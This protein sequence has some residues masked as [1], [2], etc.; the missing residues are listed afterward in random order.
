M[1]S[2]ALQSP[3]GLV[4]RVAERLAGQAGAWHGRPHL[5]GIVTGV[6]GRQEVRRSSC[7]APTRCPTLCSETIR[8]DLTRLVIL[9]S[10]APEA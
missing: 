4:D 1:M 7:F 5:P 8:T 6:A 2:S 9:Y 10:T 3:R